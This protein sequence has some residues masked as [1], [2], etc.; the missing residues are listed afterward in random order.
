[1][2]CS[3]FS[4]RFPT[5]FWQGSEDFST[6]YAVIFNPP[7]PVYIF[8]QI[9]EIIVFPQTFKLL[10]IHPFFFFRVRK[11]EASAYVHVREIPHSFNFLGRKSKQYFIYLKNNN[12]L[13]HPPFEQLGT[14]WRFFAMSFE[15]RPLR[16]NITSL[17]VLKEWKVKSMGFSVTFLLSWIAKRWK[18]KTKQTT[19]ENI[20]VYLLGAIIANRNTKISGYKVP[21]SILTSL[22]WGF[23]LYHRSFFSCRLVTPWAVSVPRNSKQFLKRYRAMHISRSTIVSVS[24]KLGKRLFITDQLELRL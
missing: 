17:F 6:K 7:P 2:Q 18:T 23:G 22:S 19:N 9:P 4:K 10:Y 14:G 15:L 21:L 13:S 8:I 24:T 11:F 12:T 16:N 3:K 5:S 20:A 1:M